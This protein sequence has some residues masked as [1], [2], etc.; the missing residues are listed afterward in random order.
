MSWLQNITLTYNIAIA[1]S[2]TN[3]WMEKS[4]IDTVYTPAIWG[5]DPWGNPYLISAE[6][7][8][9]NTVHTAQLYKKPMEDQPQLTAN[10][11]LGYDVEKWGSSGPISTFYQS[12]Y[13]N[14]YSANGTNDRV[15]DEFI[16]WDLTFKQEVSSRIALMLNVENLFNRIETRYRYN[17]VFDWGYIPTGA[18]SYGRTFDFGVRVLL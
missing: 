15:I 7:F 6:N 4:S 8:S 9:A 3:V 5:T 18:S 2:E 17:N 12:R 11:S 10:V 16:K 13:T 14:S 1:R